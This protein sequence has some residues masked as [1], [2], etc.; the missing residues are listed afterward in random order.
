MKRS[1]YGFTIIEVTITLAVVALFIMFF[2]QMYLTMES[3][4][5]SVLR[6]S[7]ASNIAYSN[8]RKFAAKPGIASC[9]IAKMDLTVNP[10][11]PGLVLGSNDNYP[12]SNRSAYG[13]VA[14]PPDSTKVL[15]QN[16]KQ[17]IL[18]FAPSGCANMNTLPIKI[19]SKV[20]YGTTGEEVSHAAFLN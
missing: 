5:L 18:A 2:F 11:A 10:N 19:V 1:S 8:M 9:D 12:T 15:G 17:T 20:T 7:I 6:R 13:F 4:R 3:Q 14:E 16:A